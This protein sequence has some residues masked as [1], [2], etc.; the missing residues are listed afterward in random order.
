MS[1]HPADTANLIRYGMDFADAVIAR[2]AGS[3]VYDTEGRAILDFTSGQ[4]CATL[5]HNH[6]EI[7]AAITLASGRSLHLFSGMLSPAVIELS[8]ELA[9]LLPAELT[10]LM[11]LNT[12]GEVNEAALRMAKLH[13]GCHEVVGFT[14]S[15]HGMTA[16]ASASTY[17]AGRRG[18]G[19][20]M[21]GVLALPAPNCFRCPIRHCRDQC[22][23][24]CLDVGFDLI[25]Q[26]STGAIAAVL[27]EP[28]Q[29]SGGVIVPPAG[30][31]VRLAEKCRERGALLILDEAQTAFG[32]LGTN[33]AFETL[34]IVPDILTLSKTLGGGLPMAA[35]A[36]SEAIEADCHAKGFMHVT[37]HVSD[38]LP[39][40]VAR[41]VLRVLATEHLNERAVTM[42][43]YLHAG[44]QSLQQRYEAI[45]D[46]RGY[47]LLYGVELVTDRDSRRPDA[48]LGAAVTRRCMELGLSMNIVSVGG[49]AAVWRIA[50][51]LTVTTSEIDLGLE[52][53]DQAMAE[54]LAA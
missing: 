21:P 53:L 26:Q 8:H 37:S 4:M 18:Y 32:R 14:G 41:A 42:G 29:S 30:Y 35:V 10:K 16:G 38:P 36:T 25:D 2:A 45:G 27:A 1:R 3:Y 52:I 17:A 44:L 6:P 51:P 7:L 23:S 24:T 43:A 50:P 33:F 15:W 47:G 48:K 12:G 19:P 22:D 13:T 39:A 5:G 9:A 46:I 34:D 31:F 20:S 40:E 49:L 11:F 28:V 54:C